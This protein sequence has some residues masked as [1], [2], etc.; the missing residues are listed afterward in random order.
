MALGIV[1]VAVTWHRDG[2]FSLP[3][4]KWHSTKTLSSARQKVLGKE[5]IAD[6]Q[7][8]E[9]SFSVVTL[10]K[11]FTECFPGFAKCFIHLAK[12]LFLVVIYGST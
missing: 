12:Q 3:S 2:D 7:F 8:T 10:G 5:A 6:V 4:T 9:T 1:S 11:A